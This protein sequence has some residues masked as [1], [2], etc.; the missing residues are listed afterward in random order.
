MSVDSARIQLAN[1]TK[2]MSASTV[3][4]PKTNSC[5][6]AGMAQIAF[7]KDGGVIRAV[8]GSCIALTLFDHERGKCTLA[9]IV[10]G[11][12]G[13]DYDGPPG[14]FATTA[15]P[16]MIKMLLKEGVPR[17]KLQAKL[18]GGSNMFKKSGPIQVGQ[19]NYEIVK[20]LLANENIPVISEHVG[21][22]KGRKIVMDSETCQMRVEVIGEGA[23]TI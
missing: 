5:Q 6:N 15:V 20:Q 1:V 2:H 17:H 8:L 12:A 14:K 19:K 16:A 13:P 10:L 23:E 18:A 9:H 3:D 7:A 4:T 11:V 21:G 22:N